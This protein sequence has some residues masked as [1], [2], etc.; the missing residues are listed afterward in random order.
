M[1]DYSL[2]SLSESKNEWCAR[3]VNTLTPAVIEGLKSIFEESWKLCQENDEEDKYLMT[4]Q[5]FLSRIPQWNPTIIETERKRIEEVS[6]CGYLEELITCVHVI[7]LKALTCVRVGQVQKKIDINIPS[8]D[9]FIHKAY[10]NVARKLYTNVYLFEKD[11]PPLDIQKNNRELELIIKECIMTSV[12]DTM[13]VEAILRAYMDETEEQ[14]V[15]I[16]EESVIIENPSNTEATDG[17]Q[18]VTANEE[19]SNAVIGDDSPA[20]KVTV[21]TPVSP[22]PA[23]KSPISSVTETKRPNSPEKIGFSDVDKAIDTAGNESAISAPK[24]IARLE[25]IAAESA[26]KRREEDG[27]DDEDQLRIGEAVKLEIG[28]INDLSKPLVVRPP[29]TLEGIEVLAPL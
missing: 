26:E 16:K 4:F 15:D 13:P 27:D 17:S 24:T 9:D 18:A 28:E 23:I 2:I 20:T 10:A 14:G 19:I 5:T 22:S 11:I 1:D 29:P 8:A 21:T 25:K 3:L 12:R 7:Q 6:G